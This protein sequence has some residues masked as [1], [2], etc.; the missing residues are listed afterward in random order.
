[1]IEPHSFFVGKSIAQSGIRD[2]AQCLV[3]GIDRADGSV[4]NPAGDEVFLP[5]DLVWVA[6]ERSRLESFLQMVTPFD[7]E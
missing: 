6:G 4:L 5:D 7:L 1:M 3:I 2:E